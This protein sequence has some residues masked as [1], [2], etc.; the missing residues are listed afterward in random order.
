[1]FSNILSIRIER[2]SQ[3]DH[4]KLDTFLRTHF[5]LPTHCRED[6]FDLYFLNRAGMLLDAIENATG[7]T[8]AGR[9]SEEVIREFGAKL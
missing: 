1:M 7:R 2:K 6:K 3:V 5:I 8:I 9:D 4:A